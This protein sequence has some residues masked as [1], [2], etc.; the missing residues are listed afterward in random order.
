MSSRRF[1]A[2]L[3]TAALAFTGLQLISSPQ[4]H[5]STAPYANLMISEVYG[6]DGSANASYHH[7]FVELFNPTASTIT[8]AANSLYLSYA[9]STAT[10]GATPVAIPA[11]SIPSD[12]HYLLQTHTGSGATPLDPG[13]SNTDATI[14]M[15]DI[16]G[17]GGKVFL[18]NT[19]TAQAA[20]G[21][22]VTGNAAIIDAVS[23][24]GQ[25]AKAYE[26]AEGTVAGGATL[27]L[28]RKDDATH[29][30]LDTNNTATDLKSA[31]PTPKGLANG[32]L[33]LGGSSP[34]ALAN[35]ANQTG[36]RNTPDQARSRWPRPAAR[37]RTRT[38]SPVTAATVSSVSSTGVITGLPAATGTY[39]LTAKSPTAR[40]R[41]RRS[42]RTSPSP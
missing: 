30:Y 32:P 13:P 18:Q 12:T 4:A 35:I 29:G 37:R 41:P 31:T 23:A 8:V 3:V 26:T 39:H 21:G 27:S 17:A 24:S 9:S 2:S 42:P 16:A 5:A 15:P 33:T 22:D 19:A 20:N 40:R 34:L 25:T 38:A 6:G 14:A 1:L 7:D 10:V 11:A 28:Q 36:F